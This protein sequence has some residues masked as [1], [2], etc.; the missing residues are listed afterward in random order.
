MAMNPFSGD[1]GDDELN[2]AINTT[3]LVDIMLVLL[4]IFLIT[5]PVVI[6]AVPVALP[7]EV[8][9]PTRT[10]PQN[11]VIAIDR[12]GG[13]FWNNRRLDDPS[14]LLANLKGRA[15]DQPQ[16][17]VH[18]RADK[19]VRYE[20]VGRVVVSC[21]RAGIRKVAFIVEPDRAAMAAR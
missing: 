16:P 19:D 9:Q 10:A 11:I 18:I 6:Q 1:E 20:F 4:I 3:P 17:E 14:Q 7:H 13:V 5:I 12:E 2:A 21:Q 15:G 8:N